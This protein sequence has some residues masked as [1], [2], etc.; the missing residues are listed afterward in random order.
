MSY[1]KRYQALTQSASIHSHS[2]PSQSHSGLSV[3]PSGPS[4]S[5]SSLC[6]IDGKDF[7][8]PKILSHH[9]KSHVNGLKCNICGKVLKNRS[10]LRK[11]LARHGP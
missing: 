11:H 1:Q 3:S 8:D 6:P 2:A 10:S 5:P 7:R 9:L 4:V